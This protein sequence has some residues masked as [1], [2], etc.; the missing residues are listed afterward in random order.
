MQNEERNQVIEK[1]LYY[2]KSKFEGESTGHD[3]WHI[4]RVWKM[5]LRIAEEEGRNVDLFVVQLAA[6]LHD[7]DDWKF[8]K[9]SE[10]KQTKEWLEKSGVEKSVVSHV[11]DIV[12]NISFKGVKVKA[13]MKTMEGKIVQDA[14]RLDAMGAVGIARCFTTGTKFNR[15]I[16]DPTKNLNKIVYD[17]RKNYSYS[18]IH[19]FYDKLLLLKDLM[20]TKTAKK[21]AEERHKFI[22]QFLDR[23]LKEWDGKL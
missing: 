2:V 10:P 20:N 12:G 1:T 6:L 16:Y 23:F 19:H 15:Q 17:L 7:L 5:A 18:S 22:E 4:Y 14:D 21:I 8:S 9:N 11:C 3:W 13:E